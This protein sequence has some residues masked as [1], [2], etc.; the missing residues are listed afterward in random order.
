MAYS[1]KQARRK[2]MG[3]RLEWVRRPLA[4]IW[5]IAIVGGCSD[6]AEDPA[7]SPT[8]ALVDP[9][10]IPA[11]PTL[12]PKRFRTSDTCAT[13]HADHAR[14]WRL[15]RHAFAMR[16]P[17]FRRLVAIRNVAKANQEDGFCTQCH[18]AIGT[19]GGE[20]VQGFNFDA[21]SPVVLEG[22]TCE[23]CHKTTEVVR[24][25]NAGHKLD[26]AVGMGATLSD[27]EDNAFHTSRTAPHMAKAE[28]CGACH[29]VVETSG[30]P[31]ERPHAE[32]QT[33]PAKATGQTCQQCHMPSRQGLAATGGATRTVHSHLFVG[34]E[35]QVGGGTTMTTA[36]RAEMNAAIGELL[37]SAAGLSLAVSPST[38]TD[39][40]LDLV[41]TVTNKIAGHN[42]PT[43]SSF[44][45]QVWV[46]ISAKDAQGKVFYASGDLDTN[47]DLRD[48]WSELDPYGDSDLIS[49][50]SRFIDT[51]GDRTLFSWEAVEHTSDA[52]EPLRQRTWTL[53]LPVPKNATG[54][55]TIEARLRFRAYG[56]FLLRLLGLADLIPGFP[57]WDIDSATAT[58]QVTP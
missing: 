48:H 18:S 6:P 31:L 11:T 41:L 27:P 40:Q 13:C 2:F 58:V 39:Q 37:T 57:I 15:S 54:P 55:L 7:D 30:L 34:V 43:G 17:V 14:E 19:R 26:A 36:D 52:I 44:L 5:L 29:D 42:F 24:T 38:A 3:L 9:L 46:E 16:D 8:L 49:L 28:F 56:P 22:V 1:G 4:V 25:F 23:A 47:G 53:F 20:C 32:W 21:L 12:D 10:S 50:S 51:K 33:S 45:R 35:T